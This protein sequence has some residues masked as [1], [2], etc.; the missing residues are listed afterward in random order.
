METIFGTETC[1]LAL[2]KTVF[3]VQTVLHLQIPMESN[4]IYFLVDT[5]CSL[6][7]NISYSRDLQPSEKQFNLSLCDEFIYD[8]FSDMP[9]FMSQRIVV[10]R[11]LP[12]IL[13]PFLERKKYSLIIRTINYFLLDKGAGEKSEMLS[14]ES[15]NMYMHALSLVY[16]D[17]KVSV[18]EVSKIV[19]Q[20]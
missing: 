9:E 20:A 14:I 10:Y 2:R 8:L 4:V 13:P 19:K 12:Y 11:S 1:F 15:W 7:D 6:R 17:E 18:D 16:Y 3:L 5:I